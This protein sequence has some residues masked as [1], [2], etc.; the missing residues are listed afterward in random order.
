MVNIDGNPEKLAIRLNNHD[1][2]VVGNL[3]V[4]NNSR[5]L[6]T[7]KSKYLVFSKENPPQLIPKGTRVLPSLKAMKVVVVNVKENVISSL[8]DFGIRVNDYLKLCFVGLKVE[9]VEHDYASFRNLTAADLKLQVFLENEIPTLVSV[10][11]LNAFYIDKSIVPFP[12]TM[13]FL[14]FDWIIDFRLF[15]HELFHALGVDHEK[16]YFNSRNLMKPSYDSINSARIT[17]YQIIRIH[18]N[19]GQMEFGL[20]DHNG[21]SHKLD[22]IEFY[23]IDFPI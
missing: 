23:K 21:S 4:K 13:G 15:I 5:N 2:S 17:P 1:S 14:N 6:K 19:I 12:N 20:R 18:N 7:D 10:N 22:K 8:T 9:F 11:D 16:P 3:H